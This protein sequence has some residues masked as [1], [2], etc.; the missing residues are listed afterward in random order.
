[1]DIT[2]MCIKLMRDAR[3]AECILFHYA[4]SAANTHHLLLMEANP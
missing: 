4:K 3:S 1:M 2:V